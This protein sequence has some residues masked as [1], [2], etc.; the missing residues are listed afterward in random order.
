M[1]TLNLTICTLLFSAVLFAS[2]PG[3][4]TKYDQFKD[5]T[6]VMVGG[7]LGMPIKGTTLS[8]QAFYEVKG[9]QAHQPDAVVLNFISQSNDWKYLNSHDLIL[10]VD[11]E[12]M[13]IG[14]LERDGTVGEGYVLEFLA[15]PLSPEKF[16][17]IANAKKVQGELFTTEFELSPAHLE[18]LRKLVHS[19]Q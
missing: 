15:A 14:T 8:M 18:I 6:S 1:K 11:G 9:K 13:P 2:A 12:R 4:Y 10:L 17:K 19:W 3:V 7:K 5:E 16:S